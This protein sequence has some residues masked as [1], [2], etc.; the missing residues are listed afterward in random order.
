MKQVIEEFLRAHGPCLTTDVSAHL[1]Q[2]LGISDAAAR[3]RTSRAGGQVKRLAYLTFPHRARFIY[4]RENFGSPLFWN[5]LISALQDS[6]S[7]YGLALAAVKA[8]N[9]VVPTA[10]FPIVSGSPNRLSKHLSHDRVLE[11][12]CRAN[13]V[14]RTHLPS[15][16]N[17][18]TLI[19]EPGHYNFIQSHL[20]AR[21]IAE[22]V[23]LSALK[24][25]IR[26]L[27]F[28]SYHKVATRD[29]GSTPTVG[30]FGWI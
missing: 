22:S 6:N 3:K 10:H 21:L 25:W 28:G 30:P 29:E 26:N 2:T 14:Q 24:A 1:V 27:T 4:L 16:G 20:R 17:S 12:L 13:L 9:G 5:R 8:R 15:I 23:L 11:N 7:A 19:E 18:V